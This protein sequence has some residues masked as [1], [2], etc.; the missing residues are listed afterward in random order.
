MRFVDEYAIDHL[1]AFAFSPEDGTPAADLPDTV[2]DELAIERV[3]ELMTLQR[4]VSARRLREL[5]G[6]TLE[7]MVDEVDEDLEYLFRGRY[8][9]QSPGIDGHVTLTD[10]R[11]NIGTSFR[12]R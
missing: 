11:A 2:P 7:V 3:D 6:S 5:R 12:R 9:G 1:G 4:A 8:Y 10:G